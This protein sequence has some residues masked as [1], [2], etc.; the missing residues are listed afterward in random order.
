MRIEKTQSTVLPSV[1]LNHRRRVLHFL[2]AEAFEQ[3]VN[4]LWDRRIRFGLGGWHCLI[5]RG[6][7]GDELLRE[8]KGTVE[9]IPLVNL[10]DLPKEEA[11]RIHREGFARYTT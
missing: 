11:R 1:S 4:D 3:A 6:D 5:L 7:I 10:R 2:T 9:E 8:F